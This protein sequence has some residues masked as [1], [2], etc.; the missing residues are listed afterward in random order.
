MPNETTGKKPAPKNCK[1]VIPE[2]K[3]PTLLAALAEAGLVLP[4]A[5]VTP[6]N[7]VAL[8]NTAAM[9]YLA[10]NGEG[11]ADTSRFDS[12]MEDQHHADSTIEEVTDMPLRMF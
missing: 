10:F 11:E 1:V 2:G 12:F 6:D 8:L 5:S 4:A 3:L 7:F 9:T